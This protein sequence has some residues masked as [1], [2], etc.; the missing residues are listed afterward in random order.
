M[1]IHMYK[2]IHM[3]YMH[4]II[5]KAPAAHFP[6]RCWEWVDEL[7]DLIVVWINFQPVAKIIGGHIALTDDYFREPFV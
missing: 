5:Q 3:S 4:T 6:Q 2:Y 1:Y 7:V